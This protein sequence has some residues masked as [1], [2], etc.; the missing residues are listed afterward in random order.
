MLRAQQERACQISGSLN[1]VQ[2]ANLLRAD[3]RG[4]RYSDLSVD[5]AFESLMLCGY[6]G[7]QFH[8]RTEEGRMPLSRAT[9]LR[10]LQL[11]CLSP[12]TSRLL[13]RYL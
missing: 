2:G 6:K 11:S 3:R 9:I 7:Q 10:R 1:S 13:A 8:A 12:I 5:L 4:Y